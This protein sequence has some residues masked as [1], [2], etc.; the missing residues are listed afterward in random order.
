M[1]LRL[2]VTAAIVVATAHAAL[3]QQ[4]DRKDPVLQNCQVKFV[5]DIEIPATE[6]G[7][8][9]HLGVKSGTQLKKDEVI[10]KI[11]DRVPQ[12]EK[13]IAEQQFRAVKKQMEEDIEKRYAEAAAKVAHADYLDLKS[14]NESGRKI[15]IDK[16]VQETD[17]RRA[18]LEHDRAVLQIEKADHDKQILEFDK[19]SRLAEY[20]AAL[21]A[22]ERRVIKAPFDGEVVE[23]FRKQ[24]EWVN[25]GDS[26]LRFV[27]YDTLKV[28]GRIRPTRNR[29][30]PGDHRM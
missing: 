4:G 25:P 27:R 30:L 19:N 12:M 13:T 20:H 18:K 15:G 29:W 7:V 2:T 10:G 1:L 21:L 8:L 3:A 9:V 26:I 22:I 14:A 24:S 16:V 17:V 28:D 23:L 6:A 11:D 5:D